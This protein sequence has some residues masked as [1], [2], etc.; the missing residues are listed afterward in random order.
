MRIRRDGRDFGSLCEAFIPP[1]RSQRTSSL[2]AGPALADVLPAVVNFLCA[3]HRRENIKKFVKGGTGEYSCWWFYNLLLKCKL[4]TS[5]TSLR[6]EHSG[7]IQ[8]NALH[9]INSIDDHQQFPAARCALHPDA[10]M[11]QRTSSSSVESMASS[12]LRA[13]VW[14]LTTSLCCN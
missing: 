1:F 14:I 6:F 2:P 4:P 11:F 7:E 13:Q 3:F 10:C 9:F 12:T 5:L 8:D